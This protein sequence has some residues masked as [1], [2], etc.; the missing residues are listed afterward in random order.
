MAIG[1]SFLYNCGSYHWSISWKH[2]V[3]QHLKQRVSG[4]GWRKLSVNSPDFFE[5]AEPVPLKELFG[6]N[7]RCMT[8]AERR[9]ASGRLE[10][11]KLIRS[12]HETYAIHKQYVFTA[13]EHRRDLA[14]YYEE[15]LYSSSDGGTY[16]AGKTF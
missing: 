10:A 15:F 7:W 9:T 16:Y 2:R 3:M 12:F 11:L 8:E 13:Y 4:T 1:T 5:A 14:R 6:R